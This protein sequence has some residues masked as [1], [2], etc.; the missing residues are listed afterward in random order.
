MN[1]VIIG[2]GATGR[3][4]YKRLSE[5]S[6]V[7]VE[8]WMARNWKEWTLS[9]KNVDVIFICTKAYQIVD[10]ANHLGKISES[11]EI[12]LCQNGLG[13]AS[14]F[15]NHSKINRKQ[16]GRALFWFGVKYD[17]KDVVHLGGNLI[18]FW[19]SNINFLLVNYLKSA[20]FE[21]QLATQLLEVEWRKA[22]IN[23]CINPLC[24]WLNCE[25]GRI[26]ESENLKF[27]WDTILK[28]TLSV[29]EREGVYFNYEEI[30]DQ[31]IRTSISTAGNKNSLL[32]DFLRKTPDELNW[33]TGYVIE[34]ARFYRI[35]VP[36]NEFIYKQLMA[37][38]HKLDL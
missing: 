24:T 34:K 1:I 3:Y 36:M 14:D 31:V 22:L 15:L 29:A 27:I 8:L 5:L 25:N 21:I 28:E 16:I 19:Q 10:V 30:K 37:L 38:S 12:I 32:Q 18:T 2:A 35:N 20:G 26:A 33:L 23:N 6:E 9:S 13:I 11:I 7:S 4:L 17:C